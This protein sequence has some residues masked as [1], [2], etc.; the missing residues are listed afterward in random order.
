MRTLLV[1]LLILG[2]IAGAIVVYLYATTPNESA[3]VSFPITADQRALLARVPAGADAWALIPSA[4]V[5]HQKLLANAVTRGPVQEW[6]E[7]ERMPEPW[8][9]GG[10]D[11]LAWRDQK[12]TSYAI[13]VD[14]FRAFLVRIWMMWSSGAVDARWDGTA[15]VINGAGG[16][17]IDPNEIERILAL[18]S[19]LP[20]GDVFVAQRNRTRGAFPP[21]GRPAVSSVVVNEREIVSVSRAVSTRAEKP[22][23]A[24]AAA[25]P[26]EST[27]PKSAVL[28]VTF[29]EP[30]SLLGDLRRLTGTN[31]SEL[32]ANGGS[33]TI[34]D[35]DTGTLLPRP[36]GLIAVPATDARRAAMADVLRVAE[37][38]GQTED[39]GRELLVAF[40]RQSLPLYLKDARVPA[41]W[42]ATSWAA[43]IDPVKLVPILEKMGDSTG[44]RIASGRLH[45]AA[46][47]LRRWISA[48][49]QAESIEAAASTADGAEELRVR[50]ASK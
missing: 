30:P 16:P 21:I 15:F 3:G 20:R 45:R 28:A 10:A 49:E 33:I 22:E 39:T 8:M 43:R 17:P 38:V 9:L 31:L 40:D 44:L 14:T 42:P 26:L 7:R 36:K 2:L 50:I 24:E 27:F 37:L 46:R 29:N 13:R 47:D 48:L 12:R 18:A 19:G 23:E 11:V 5:M 1:L 25:A 32:A 6:T 41:T 34:Y 4:A 35:V